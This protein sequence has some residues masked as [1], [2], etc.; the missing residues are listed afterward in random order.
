[1][2]SR[3]G[4]IGG[5]VQFDRVVVDA[6]VYI[7]FSF[8]KD[9]DHQLSTSGDTGEGGALS[10]RL[11]SKK[12]ARCRGN[13]SQNNRLAFRPCPLNTKHEY[14]KMFI[15]HVILNRLLALGNRETTLH[16]I[17]N[18]RMQ[19]SKINNGSL[20]LSSLTQCSSP[21]KLIESFN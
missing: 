15:T 19:Q 21:T 7:R 1:M 17:G 9:N 18:N 20:I 14:S 6:T 10:R 16:H 11:A 12:T 8:R 2:G 4:S 3:A 5:A 13:R